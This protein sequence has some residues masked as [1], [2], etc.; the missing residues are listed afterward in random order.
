MRSPILCVSVVVVLLAASSSQA[1]TADSCPEECSCITLDG[2]STV[3]CTSVSSLSKLSQKQ[4]ANI[5][6][7]DISN[8]TTTFIDKKLV[9]KLV[10]LEKLNVANN[11][12]SDIKHFHYL[13]K[14]TYLNLKSNLLKTFT[15]KYLP[16]SLRKLDISH[17]YIKELPHDLTSCPNLHVIN[18]DGNSFS[19]SRESLDYRDALVDKNIKI[20]GRATCST[21][22]KLLGKDWKVTIDFDEYFKLHHQDE[23]LGD[24]ANADFAGSGEGSGYGPSDP[25]PSATSTFSPDTDFSFTSGD[26]SGDEPE[27]SSDRDEEKYTTVTDNF[28][29]ITTEVVEAPI[30]PSVVG[31]VEATPKSVRDPA[32][33][34][35]GSIYTENPLQGNQEKDKEKEKGYGTNIFLAVVVIILIGLVIYAV[36]KNKE[37]KR[38]RQRQRNRDVE[39]QNAGIELLPKASVPNEKQNGNAET[40]PLI[41]PPEEQDE[42]ETELLDELPQNGNNSQEV[43][44]PSPY[45]NVSNSPRDP[46]REVVSVKVKASEIPDSIPRTPILVDRRKTP[47]GQN[48]IVTPNLNQR[49]SNGD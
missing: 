26:G 5:K 30:K 2:I 4:L 23:M 15:G 47:D 1:D 29:E 25:F 37:R 33:T 7:L 48:I 28:P 43:S 49:A 16:K 14:L 27:I 38:R 44:S 35:D 36:K 31:T 13:N 42:K 32:T 3:R 8:S 39:K 46:N 10:N 17:N 22:S 12:I 45:L 18:V 6:S 19:C 34:E 24:D 11:R 9:K 40:S 41:N 21:P 20:I